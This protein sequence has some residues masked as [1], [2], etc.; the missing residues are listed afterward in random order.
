[1]LLLDTRSPMW[2]RS[3]S[4]SSVARGGKGVL[5]GRENPVLDRLFSELLFSLCG[6]LRKIRSRPSF[7]GLSPQTSSHP[8]FTGPLLCKEDSPGLDRLLTVQ[9]ESGQ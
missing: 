3:L 5:T 1:M 2:S 6:D 4:V 7:P 8:R 9:E